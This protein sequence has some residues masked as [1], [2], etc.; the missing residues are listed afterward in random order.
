MTG[1]P[2]LL[3]IWMQAVCAVLAAA[4]GEATLVRRDW[5]EA[6]LG[7]DPDRGSGGLERALVLGLFVAAATLAIQAARGW[8]RLRAS[9]RA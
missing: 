8:L 2:V 7:I 4:L 1:R 5:I 6:V 9:A 3:Q